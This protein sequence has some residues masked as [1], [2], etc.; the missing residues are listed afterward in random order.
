MSFKISGMFCAKGNHGLANLFQVEKQQSFDP[1]KA[2]KWF[3]KLLG[4]KHQL[5]K[6]VTHDKNL[7]KLLSH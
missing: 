6:R 3:K 1:V 2:G 4:S 7:S 5:Y